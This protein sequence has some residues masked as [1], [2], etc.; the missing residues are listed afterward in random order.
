MKRTRRPA[1]CALGTTARRTNV[2]ESVRNLKTSALDVRD[3]LNALEQDWLV[4]RLV[5]KTGV[6]TA[7]CNGGDPLR[8][9]VEYDADLL[10]GS[11]LLEFLQIC[12]LHAKPA[13]LLAH[14]A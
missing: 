11:D 13:P 4:G 12:G 3:P 1:E 9:T 14:R 6:H 8:L 7:L 10:N 2:W 5:S